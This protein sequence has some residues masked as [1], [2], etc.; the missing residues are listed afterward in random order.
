M[1]VLVV[2]AHHDD[3]EIGCGATVAKLIDA[4]HSVTSVVMTHSGYQAPDNTL[5]RTKDAALREACRASEVLGYRLISFDDDTFD[6][7]ENDA[8]VRK[9]LDVM[10]QDA[11]D[12]IFTHWHGDTHP[13]HRRINRMVLH[14]A[15][16]IP[17]VLGFAANWYCGDRSFD[18]RLLV[19]INEAQWQRKIQALRCYEGEF[20]RT[21]E[22]WVNYLDHRSLELGI[23][24]GSARAEAFV[25]Y[26]YLWEW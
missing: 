10:Q 16:H 15:R 7:A 19:P 8:N 22:K 2:S 20:Q 4:G 14:A 26:R 12:T 3:L 6:L 1:R 21:G 13:P 25:V 24:V 9:I 17:R 23:Q 11:V 18:P 5:V